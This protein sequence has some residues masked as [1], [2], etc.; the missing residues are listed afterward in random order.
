[1]CVFAPVLCFIFADKVFAQDITQVD[2]LSNIPQI[3]SL[4]T[5]TT[6]IDTLALAKDTVVTVKKKSSNALEHPVDFAA[7]DSIVIFGDGRV[8]MYK[9]GI[10]L[11]KESKQ[12]EIR[13]DF[14]T[15][16]MDSS[17]MHAEGVMDTLGNLNGKP[18][19]KDGGQAYEAK[20]INYNFK[21][22]KGYIRG[23][24][25]QEGE[26]YIIADRTKKTADGYMNM[27]GGMYTTCDNHDHPHF[28]L[29][30][31]KGKVKPGGYVAAGPAYMVVEDVPL[32][33][34]IPFG[35]F[36]FT[37]K[38]SSGV[39]MPSYGDE[40]VHGF[41][42]KDGGY[43]FAINDYVDLAL[44]GDIY[45][46]GSWKIHAESRYVKRYKFSGNVNI[47]Y[48][49]TVD[50]QKDMPDYRVAKNFNIN[51]Q[52]R[53]DAKSNPFST[54]SASVDFVTSGYNRNEITY[55]SNPA[56]QSQNTTSSS[57]NY[58]RRFPE[59]PF[60]LSLNGSITQTM[61]DSTLQIT[62]PNITLDV[63]RI[64]PLKRRKGV[65]KERFY[66]K[67]AFSYTLMFANSIYTKE[68]KLLKSSFSKDWS[69]GIKHS[70]KISLPLTV[71][72]YLNIT[73]SFEYTESWEF[74]KIDRDWNF[75][76]Q[77][78]E[79]DTVSGFYRAYSFS[80]GVS[81]STKLYGFYS[82]IKKI[83]DA[84]GIGDIR[85]LFTPSI[86]F[87]YRPDFS[88]PMWKLFKTYQKTT[89][90]PITQQV[91]SQDVKYTP[92]AGSKFLVPSA[93][94]MNS[95]TFTIDNNV[96]MKVKDKAASDTTGNFIYK[97]VSIIDNFNLSSSYNFVAD[98]MKLAPIRAS[99]RI[100][101]SKSIT[102]N[103]LTTFDPYMYALNSEGQ[104]VKIDEF[105]WNHGKFP[106]F[107]GTSTNFSHTI[108]NSTFKKKDKKKTEDEQNT[109]QEEENQDQF[110]LDITQQQND[111]ISQ[112]KKVEHDYEGYQKPDVQW[113]LS[114]NY[115]ITYGQSPEFDFEKMEYKRKFTTSMLSINGY[116]NPTPNWQ[117][118]YTASIE[119][120]KQIK[121]TSMVF[122]VSRNL[123]CWKLTA[124]VTPF[125]YYKSF[126]IT[127]GANAAMLR[128]LK[129][130]KHNRDASVRW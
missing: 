9:N 113:S 17:T 47:N 7:E 33:L 120:R 93:G 57:V 27:K 11:Y 60:S 74:K 116:I 31:T 114:F 13:A 104:P 42:L 103:L 18:V 75:D 26:G 78:V 108:N 118:S 50:G 21:T 82:P 117:F 106:Y 54:F 79:Y 88:D 124:S 32:P 24:K 112:N 96:E 35:F 102:L 25:T 83:R 29:N 23:A 85:H 87:S 66:E 55:I 43:Y 71:F 37:S 51:W 89:T 3:D 105:R 99:L 63:S 72:K 123:H 4:T 22:E 121:I 126:M 6:V 91:V 70:P 92:F 56:E 52:H 111:T 68:N 67:F 69:N 64:Y 8:M 86:G 16:N 61:R 36:P 65:G 101:L 119:L 19:F 14:I 129:Y 40:M 58:T 80:A 38:Y 95:L 5:D 34:A 109:G 39:I 48:Q 81:M 62:F 130:D 84:L 128:D 41:F 73:P 46:K 1:L 59:T 76:N 77:T 122:N 100:K 127:I 12:K 49:N 10:V 53:Q 98:S 94:K 2:S 20:E 30:L 90:D 45:T 107:T 125:G 110:S 15:V 115:S 44:T 97:K 28:Y